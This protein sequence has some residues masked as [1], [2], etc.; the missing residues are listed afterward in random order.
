MCFL[1]K[2]G[3]CQSSHC[4]IEGCDEEKFFLSTI[5]YFS[6]ED[7]TIYCQNDFRKS[8]VCK[9]LNRILKHY[10]CTQNNQCLLIKIYRNLLGMEN[11]LKVI[12]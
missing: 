2:Q 6:A 4:P 1:Q 7:K 8:R 12:S 5:V 9:S 10:V 3:N 11:E